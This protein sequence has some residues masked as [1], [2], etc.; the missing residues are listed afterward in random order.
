MIN[1]VFESAA[2]TVHSPMGIVDWFA[3]AVC[4]F[5]VIHFGWQLIVLVIDRLEPL[6]RRN[7]RKVG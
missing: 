1:R 7:M 4:L 5:M 2:D 3:L 6:R